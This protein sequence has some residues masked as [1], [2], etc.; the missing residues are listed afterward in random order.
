MLE[1]GSVPVWPFDLLSVWVLML[2]L[3]LFWLVGNN[4]SRKWAEP[5]QLMETGRCGWWLEGSRS[6]SVSRP[7]GVIQGLE[8]CCFSCVVVVVIMAVPLCWC[9]STI[10]AIFI[11]SILSRRSDPHL[12]LL[13]PPSYTDYITPAAK[14]GEIANTDV[15]VAPLV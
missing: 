1:Q 14:Q 7:P 13:D 3:P 5:L 4:S 9:V 10:S 8:C 6:R 12:L 11:C 2:S 15:S